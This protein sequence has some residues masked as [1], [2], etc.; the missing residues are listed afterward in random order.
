MTACEVEC[1]LRVCPLQ[2]MV[3][4]AEARFTKELAAGAAAPA[5]MPKFDALDL[6]SV[7][8]KYNTV[9]CL[10]VMIHY[11]QVASGSGGWGVVP[12][13]P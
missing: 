5:V 6:E 10:D 7:S 8:G 9:T 4:E 2:A 11:P 13:N 1:F 12:F 3:G